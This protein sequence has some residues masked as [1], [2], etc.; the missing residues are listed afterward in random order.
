MIKIYVPLDS[1]AIALGADEVAEAILAEAQKRDETVQLVRNGSR[2]M[3]WLEPLVEVEQS[4]KRIGFANVD[5][6]DVAA[7][8]DA[9]FLN[10]A[11]H[12][13]CIGDVDDHPF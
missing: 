1:A 5:E 11:D 7:L 6:S 2:G 12:K 4:G 10:K 3:H 8:F 13:S 9:G